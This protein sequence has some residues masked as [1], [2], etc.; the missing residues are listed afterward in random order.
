MNSIIDS[1]EYFWS[2]ENEFLQGIF[3]HAK[4]RHLSEN[5]KIKIE[6]AF[7][8]ACEAHAEQ[9]RKSDHPYMDHISEVLWDYLRI[10]RKSY[11][12]RD[13]IIVVL[14]HDVLE[15]HPEFAHKIM[16]AFGDVV[17]ERVENVSKPSTDVLKASQSERI[18]QIFSWNGYEFIVR[19]MN[20]TLSRVIEIV[21]QTESHIGVFFH[22]VR[23]SGD[24]LKDTKNYNFLWKIALLSEDDFEIKCADRM[25]NLKHLTHVKKDYI[26]KNLRSTKIYIMKA[27]ALKRYDLVQE[28][29]VGM[30]ALRIRG[31]KLWLQQEELL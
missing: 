20:R 5:D 31:E 16:E 13:D 28:L 18:C 29:E 12:D 23:I 17:F 11:I 15:D 9:T 24:F 25:S 27:Q 19:S 4:C 14:L 2:E 8:L 22:M 30:D 3:C 1:S 21:S 7:S 6:E 26:I 10:T